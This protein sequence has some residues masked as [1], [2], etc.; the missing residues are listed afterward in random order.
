MAR[1]HLVC[2]IDV[3]T[4]KITTLIATL[5]EEGEAVVSGVSP[6][7]S[8]GI[9]KGQVVNMRKRPWPFLNP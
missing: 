2:A 3:G 8:K 5:S 9:R 6:V 1:D 4:S 7:V